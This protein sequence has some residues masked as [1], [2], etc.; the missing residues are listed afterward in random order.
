MFPFDITPERGR[1]CRNGLRS[2][3]KDKD[4]VS[5]LGVTP[6]LEELCAGG[7]DLQSRKHHFMESLC[8]DRHSPFMSSQSWKSR[9]T[10]TLTHT[11]RWS[12][13]SFQQQCWT[14]PRWAE[15]ETSSHH[16]SRV[17]QRSESA[18]TR[19]Y[20]F[21]DMISKYESNRNE[22]MSGLL[23]DYFIG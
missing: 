8:G 11:L 19:I 13:H 21:P 12:Q 23:S 6:P 7:L 4:Q 20:R 5:G 10:H 22:N 1:S 15:A 9:E 2:Y 16:F 14:H 18:V 17:S 3:L